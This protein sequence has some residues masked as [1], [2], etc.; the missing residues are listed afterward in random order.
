MI[1]NCTRI[2][3]KQGGTTVQKR[4]DKWVFLENYIPLTFSNIDLNNL[5][6]SFITTVT[7]TFIQSLFYCV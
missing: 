1:I 4:L 6:E 7:K 2:I 3:K 5:S